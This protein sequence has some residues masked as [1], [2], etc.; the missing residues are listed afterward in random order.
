MVPLAEE[1]RPVSL[2][3]LG[4]SSLLRMLSA[5]LKGPSSA[6]AQELLA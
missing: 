5:L 6:G 2:M 4:A 1:L 3:P